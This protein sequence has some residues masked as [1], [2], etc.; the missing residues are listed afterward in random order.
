MEKQPALQD[1]LSEIEAAMKKPGL[2][3]NTFFFNSWFGKLEIPA[4]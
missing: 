4:A 2:K 1:K 3:I